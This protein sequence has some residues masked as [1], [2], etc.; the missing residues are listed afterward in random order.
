MLKLILRKKE[1][2]EEKERER[3]KKQR[4]KNKGLVRELDLSEPQFPPV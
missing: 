1:R 3:E 4:S 2:E